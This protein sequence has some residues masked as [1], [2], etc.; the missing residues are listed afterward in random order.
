ML[1]HSH[2]VIQGKESSKQT[3]TTAANKTRGSGADPRNW[4]TSASSVYVQWNADI[5]K[6]Q[7]TGKITSLYR[8]IVSNDSPF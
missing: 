8:G 4:L 1:C 6:H 3:I 5:V 7:G 2:L